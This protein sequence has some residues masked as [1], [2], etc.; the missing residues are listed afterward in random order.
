MSV[1]S[2][3]CD[4]CKAWHTEG[5]TCLSTREASPLAPSPLFGIWTR[6]AIENGG[7]LHAV[8]NHWGFTAT[9]LWPQIPDQ[10]PIE[11]E[12]KTIYGAFA[13]LELALMEDA[14]DEMMNNPNSGV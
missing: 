8:R 6:V 9:I 7:V 11:G 5:E 3:Y 13:R 12:D 2:K 1:K 4:H 14:G 10:G